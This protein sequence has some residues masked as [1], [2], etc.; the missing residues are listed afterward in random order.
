MKIPKFISQ[1]LIKKG[2]AR[3]T[4]KIKATSSEKWDAEKTISFLFSKEAELIRPWQFREEI[5]GMAQEIGKIKPKVVLEI[6]TAN[7]GTLFMACR[8][9]DPEA[10]IISIDLPGGAFGG[11]YPEWKTPIYSSFA[12][13]KQ[14]IKLLRGSSHSEE[15]I[16][17]LKKILA[18]RTIDYLFI[19]G[20][21]SY[22]GAKKDYEIYTAFTSNTAVISF[23]DIVKHKDDSCDVYRVWQELKQK[24]PHKEYVNNWDQ[25]CFGVGILY[26]N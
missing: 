7:G 13:E 24:H 18:G 20:D 22:E 3:L 1:I 17:E 25:K 8:M 26:K 16:N 15:I 12:G 19:D 6:G 21:H 4:K 23:H 2:F 11:G 9:S 5:L 10:L 14:T